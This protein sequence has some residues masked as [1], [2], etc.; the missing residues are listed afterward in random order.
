MGISM[1]QSFTL[2]RA[3]QLSIYASLSYAA[4]FIGSTYPSNS[5]VAADHCFNSD[6]PVCFKF[7]A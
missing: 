1:D 3:C 5:T 7:M 6:F 2:I 4:R